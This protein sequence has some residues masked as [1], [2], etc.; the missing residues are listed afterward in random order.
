MGKTLHREEI[1]PRSNL[2]FDLK[3]DIPKY[4]LGGDAFKTRVFDGVQMSFPDGERYFIES[5]RAYKDQIKDP[6][7]LKQVKDF[8]WQEGQHGK[9]HTEYNERMKEQ[10]VPVDRFLSVVKKVLNRRIK[11]LPKKYNIAMTSALEHFTA[12]M[13]ETFFAKKDVMAQADPRMRAMLAWHAIEEMEHKA[14][15]FDVMQKVAGVGYALRA[16][17]MC[18]AIFAFTMHTM[19]VTWYLLKVDGFTGWQRLQMYTKGMAWLFGPGGLYTS[20]I[21]SLLT[22]FKPGFHPWHTK[23]IHSYGVWLETF[24]QSGS[25]LEAGEAM[26]AAAY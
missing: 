6:E 1:V 17:T 4:W 26:Y 5:V 7:L 11:K 8:T 20:L 9:V 2:D 21:P 22:Y 16:W 18:H 10:G 19:L 12:M 3:G 24:E 25:A 15:A 14:V 13:A 23:T